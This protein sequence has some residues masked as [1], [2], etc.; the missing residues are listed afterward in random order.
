M[1]RL[2]ICLS[3]LLSPLLVTLPP[4]A[5]PE[6][7]GVSPPGSKQ[8][9]ADARARWEASRK[10]H[11]HV[12][13]IAAEARSQSSED[14][15]A[16]SGMVAESQGASGNLQAL[17]ASNQI[18]AL[19]TQRLMQIEALLAASAQAEAMDC[20]RELAE[21]ERGRARLSTFLGR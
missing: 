12:L 4:L 19:T 18:S 13:M 15:E 8:L 11:K 7:Y 1:R 17:Q 2:E 16:L 21:A 6:S 3:V 20:A 10:A 14:A 9:V 5:Y